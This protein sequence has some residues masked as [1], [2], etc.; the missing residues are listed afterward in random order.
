MASSCVCACAAGSLW[1]SGAYAIEGLNW[2]S[3]TRSQ[4]INK[5]EEFERNMKKNEK[6]P[7]AGGRGGGRRGGRFGEG[8][9]GRGASLPLRLT[10][11]AG[12]GSACSTDSWTQPRGLGRV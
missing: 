11:Y 8:G 5:V 6:R 2:P 9:G 7:M 4:M 10:A 12:E 3:Q 1:S